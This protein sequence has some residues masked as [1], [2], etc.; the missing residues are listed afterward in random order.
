MRPLLT[1]LCTLAFAISGI[2]LAI[3]EKEHASSASYKTMRAATLS[4][5]TLPVILPDLSKLPLDVQADLEKKYKKTDTVYVPQE[6]VVLN[7]SKVNNQKLKGKRTPPR[8]TKKRLGD[9]IPAAI[10]D[11]LVKNQVCGARE[12]NT[13]DSI[14]P[15]KGSICLTVDGEVVYKR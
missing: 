12:E 13:P 10:P 14:G 9:S 6:F 1:I 7:K 11:T 3:S 2:S 4:Q 8:A 5:T 15:P